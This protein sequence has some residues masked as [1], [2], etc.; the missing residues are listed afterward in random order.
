MSL[1]RGRDRQRAFVER[2]DPTWSDTMSEFSQSLSGVLHVQEDQP[3]DESV[4]P[5]PGI[6]RASIAKAEGYVGDT[7]R[8]ASLFG[9]R[10]STTIEIDPHN[11]TCRTDERAHED[12]HVAN[13]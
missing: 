12:A 8:G 13:S 1:V 3:P 9:D 10:E 6:C 4:K 11:R 7:L 5:S 2:D